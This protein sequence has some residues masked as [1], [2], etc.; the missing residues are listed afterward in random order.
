MSHA[1]LINQIFRLFTI[2][3]RIQINQIIQQSDRE[4]GIH[5][6]RFLPRQPRISQRVKLRSRTREKPTIRIY[7]VSCR[8]HANWEINI[9]RTPISSSYLQSTN[10]P[11]IFQKFV[12]MEIYSSPDRPERS[13]TFILTEL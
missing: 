9:T 6:I 7:L 3:R 8:G 11:I 12:I 5:G 2:I 1:D 10:Q 4:T 13:P